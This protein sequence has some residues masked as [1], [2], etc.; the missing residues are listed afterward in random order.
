MK[1][2]DFKEKF[3]RNCGFSKCKGPTSKYFI[4]CKFQCD[5]HDYDVDIDDDIDLSKEQ[6]IRNW[7]K[8]LYIMS[9]SGY[10]FM[11]IKVDE[12]SVYMAGTFIDSGVKYSLY[13]GWVS[14]WDDYECHFY[15]YEREDS[16]FIF[17][18]R[19]MDRGK[20]QYRYF[21]YSSIGDYLFEYTETDSRNLIL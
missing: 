15:W 7:N 1:E 16:S 8:I 14:Y 3:C 4:D 5:Y 6:V 19:S 2:E 21:R 18:L 10:D 9:S 13:E 12:I 17:L 11:D 20:D